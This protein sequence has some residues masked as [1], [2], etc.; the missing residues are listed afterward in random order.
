[1]PEM[2]EPARETQW[3]SERRG[4]E[5]EVGG[6]E[7]RR[8]RSSAGP[9]ASETGKGEAASVAQAGQTEPVQLILAC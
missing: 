4:E 9:W 7:C 6:A 2:G 3:R 1:M 8:R 5:V